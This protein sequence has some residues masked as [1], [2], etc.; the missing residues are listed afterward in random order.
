[1]ISAE[2]GEGDLDSAAGPEAE[3][4]AAEGEAD[5]RRRRRGRRGGRRTRHGRGDGE[6][7]PAES[8]PAFATEPDPQA[9]EPVA[10]A[11]PPFDPR[12]AEVMRAPDRDSALPEPAA[13]PLVETVAEPAITH[14]EPSRRGSTVREPAP[15]YFG[16]HAA[17]P[18]SVE[19]AEPE[20]P[21][22][23]ESGGGE[24]ED[25]ARP[26]RSGWWRK[27]VLGKG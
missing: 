23:T 1:M 9:G 19:P 16:G 5:R 7:S 14:P 26:R 11:E 15:G 22:V 6:A 12:E 24:S 18:P 27:R 3:S 21:V 17:P 25:E 8:T 4:E 10:E 20:P 2:P 13:T